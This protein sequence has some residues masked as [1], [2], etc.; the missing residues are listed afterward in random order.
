MPLDV[1]DAV[2][3]QTTRVAE[4]VYAHEAGPET[5][6]GIRVTRTLVK[7]EPEVEQLVSTDRRLSAE[8]VDVTL[9]RKGFG[10]RVAIVAKPMSG[11]DRSDLEGLLNELAEPQKRPFSSAERPPP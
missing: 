11:L 3:P 2:A 9:E 7:S 8:G 4:P 6:A 1:A 5:Q 10:T